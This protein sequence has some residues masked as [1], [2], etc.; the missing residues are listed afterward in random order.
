MRARAVTLGIAVAT[1]ACGD[2]Q[3]PTQV[4]VLVD[5]E[6]SVRAA[7]LTLELHVARN[8]GEPEFSDAPTRPNW[9]VTLVLAPSNDEVTAAIA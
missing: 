2:A 5:A 4:V 9:P 1:A 8:S 6:E 7:A 3:I